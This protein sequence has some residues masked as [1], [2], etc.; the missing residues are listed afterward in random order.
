[1]I[2]DNIKVT[3]L[4][5]TY[6]CEKFLR[7][8]LD[9]IIYQTHTNWELI[10]SDDSSSDKTSDILNEYKLKYPEKIYI[11]NN[12]KRFG[13][14]RDNF[15]HLLENCIGSYIMF[16][17]HDDKWLPKK[18][19]LTLAKMLETEKKQPPHTPVLVH[20]DLNVVDGELNMIAPSLMKFQD[21]SPE[22]IKLNNLLVQNVITGCTVMINKELKE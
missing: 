10:V 21:I 8:Q 6:N 18:I 1:M 20:T 3:I 7:T 14:A 22:R 15:F 16:C 19:E 12:E 2:Q 5:A 11:L 17:D 13:N 4:L 9:S